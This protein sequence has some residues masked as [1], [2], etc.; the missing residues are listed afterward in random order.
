MKRKKSYG[1]C[2]TKRDHNVTPV[3]CCCA[4]HNPCAEHNGGCMHECRVDGGRAH[5]DCKE[6][7]ILGEDR[8][9]CRGRVTTECQC[10]CQSL[11]HVRH[12]SPSAW[13]LDCFS[14]L[15]QRCLIVSQVKVV[16]QSINQSI[17]QSLFLKKTYR[18][19]II[20]IIISNDIKKIPS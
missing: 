10:H 11:D 19:I 3:F 7:Y 17:N 1:I 16:N 13:S 12:V 14:L 2:G 9:T 6:G 20:M 5:C 18:I 8:K 15:L 4:V